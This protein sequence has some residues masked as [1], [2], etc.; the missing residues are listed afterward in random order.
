MSLW[1][2]L[3]DTAETAA[4]LAG[5]YYMPGSSMLTSRL[6]S[7]GSQK[8]LNS[9]V[10]QLAQLGTGGYGAYDEQMGNWGKLL[11][12]GGWYG[13]PSTDVTGSNYLT[14]AGQLAKPDMSGATELP[15]S[16]TAIDS[17]T[18]P[19]P[20]APDATKPS[21]MD[22]PLQWMKDH[23][24]AVK[25]A[26]YGLGAAGLLGLINSKPNYLP[27]YQPPTA[28]QY[29]L[30]AT[31]A[32][33][34]RPV[35]TMAVG[36]ITSLPVEQMSNQ[37]D[38]GQNTGY[39][40][41]YIGQGA[42]ATPWQTPISRNVLSGPEDVGVNPNTDQMVTEGGG[43][44]ISGLMTYARGGNVSMQ[45]LGSYS[46]G[47]QMLKG[48]GDGMSDSI[49]ASISGK[50]PARL[51]DGEFVVPADVVSH[52]GNGSTDAGARQ[53]YKMMDRIRSARTGKKKQAPQVN[54]HKVMPA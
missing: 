25:M 40:Q 19:A 35:R 2:D 46:D 1:T 38:V 13:T 37:N 30:G 8:Q 33:N 39:P 36:G 23:K 9:G 48:P 31:L 15:P 54:P 22:D 7:E 41:A 52:L 17:T 12:G 34:Y 44:G 51:A 3:R 18:A 28:Q 11:P 10:G 5:N 24:Q 43:G 45:N 47:G 26:G 50:Q 27:V 49:P 6:T 32:S 16:P 21:F 53:L 14:D 42:Y 20:V 4:V 29:G